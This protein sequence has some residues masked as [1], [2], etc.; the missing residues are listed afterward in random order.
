MRWEWRRIVG[1]RSLGLYILG[2]GF[3][4]G[5]AVERMRFDRQRQ[6]VV[7]RLAERAD[8]IHAHL[9]ALER[10]DERRA[11]APPADAP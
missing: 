8:R 4:S 7:G 3:V 10:G 2:F 11:V 5:M 1:L 9:M 6:Q